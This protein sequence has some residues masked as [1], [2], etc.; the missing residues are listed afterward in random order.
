MTLEFSLFRFSLYLSKSLSGS[1]FSSICP[2]EATFTRVMHLPINL[3]HCHICIL[4]SK[5]TSLALPTILNLGSK[6][7]TAYCIT[8]ITL[9]CYGYLKF[10]VFENKLNFLAPEIYSSFQFPDLSHSISNHPFAKWETLESVLSPSS[11]SPPGV[12]MFVATS[13]LWSSIPNLRNSSNP[14]K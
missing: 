13:I 3:V 9:M 4:V 14:Q 2:S 7:L 1:S 6:L 8:V 5:Y 11:P 12:A 10:H